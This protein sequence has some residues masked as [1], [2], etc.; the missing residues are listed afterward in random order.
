M[1]ATT[2]E[3]QTVWKGSSSQAL[4]LRRYVLC[5]LLACLAAP[6][7]YALWKPMGRNALG[8]GACWLIL[9][10]FYALW[11][12]LQV[13]SRQ[14]EVT[15]ERIRVRT[16]IFSKR[17]EDLELYRVKDY[18][19]VE[20]FWLRVFGAGT[21]RLTTHDATNPELV[22][23]AVPRASALRDEIRKHVEACRG[24]KG[25]RVSEWE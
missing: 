11:T 2:N 22:I 24:R 14:Y 4:Y 5:I 6:I 13:R 19:L 21:I 7:A 16:G 23:E 3:E 17:T 15:T 18:E 8:V 20:P 9:P 10:I 12:W 25:V 1:D